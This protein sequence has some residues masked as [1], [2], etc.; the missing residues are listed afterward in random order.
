MGCREVGRDK[1]NS[2][3]AFAATGWMET[4]L[5]HP[6]LGVSQPRSGAYRCGRGKNGSHLSAA[7]GTD[8]SLASLRVP[9]QMRLKCPLSWQAWF[10]GAKAGT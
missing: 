1:L 4:A 8:G 2:L 3:A 10:P 9:E 6:G 5:T 7:S